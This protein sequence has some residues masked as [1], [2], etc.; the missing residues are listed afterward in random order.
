MKS[1]S[2]SVEAAMSRKD[3]LRIPLRVESHRRPHGFS[4]RL[5]ELIDETR[6]RRRYLDDVFLT[7]PNTGC[8]K[9]PL[10]ARTS[11]LQA[12]TASEGRRGGGVGS[13]P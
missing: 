12:G 8:R 9:C 11:G 10:G 13:T 2:E 3:A 6:H 4:T 7:R 5:S 1:C